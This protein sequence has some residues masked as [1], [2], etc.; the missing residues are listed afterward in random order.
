MKI[1]SF[2]FRILT[3][4]TNLFFN[5]KQTKQNQTS[6]PTFLGI[7]PNTLSQMVMLTSPT[8]STIHTVQDTLIMPTTHHPSSAS[9]SSSS[10][11][12]FAGSSMSLTTQQQPNN[13]H[14]RQQFPSTSTQI[15]PATSPLGSVGAG[16]TAFVVPTSIYL[17][18]S[19]PNGKLN[20]IRLMIIVVRSTTADVISVEAW[21]V[22]RNTEELLFL[23]FLIFLTKELYIGKCGGCY[24]HAVKTD[25]QVI[26]KFI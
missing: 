22:Y 26:D 6:G 11:S 1:I 8:S 5:N 15:L 20:C 12:S 18:S 25:H 9:T 13:V 2:S 4:K 10:S 7:I 14:G 19:R 24:R 16:H 23:S 21:I 3:S 17:P